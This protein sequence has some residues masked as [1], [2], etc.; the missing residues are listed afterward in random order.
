MIVLQQI[1]VGRSALSCGSRDRRVD[2]VDV[3]AVDVGNDVP[4]VGLEAPRRVVGEPALDLAVDRD[5]VVVVEADQLRQAQR[6]GERAG[7]VRDAFHQAA[8]ADEHVGAMVDDRMAGA[9]ELGREQPFGERHADRVGESL[10]ERPGRRLDARRHADFRMAG[11]LRV[12]LAKAPELVDRQRVAGQVQQRVLQH[13]AVAVRQHEAVA[14]GPVRI[15]RV[16]AQVP[17]P[18]RDG[19]FGHAHRHAGMAGVGRL[20][21][22]HRERADR[23]GEQRRIARE[24]SR[25]KRRLRLTRQADAVMIEGSPG[26]KRCAANCELARSGAAKR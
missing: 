1:S 9:I 2:G 7:F 3:V 19:D 11:R 18:Q 4:A 20:H 23:V 14:I 25:R 15:G 24:R 6:A 8:V 10:A 5:A 21:R 12:Q 17:V 16:V 26:W 22:V 13:R